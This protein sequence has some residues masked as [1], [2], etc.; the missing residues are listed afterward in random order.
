MAA[1]KR[2][3]AAIPI[4][5]TNACNCG[6]RLRSRSIR[7][8]SPFGSLFGPLREF[9]HNNTNKYQT[10]FVKKRKFVSII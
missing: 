5:S 2:E 3:N 10:V 7:I 6:A 4:N 8:G 1:A 9:T